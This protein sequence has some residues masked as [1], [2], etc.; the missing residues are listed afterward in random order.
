MNWSRLLDMPNGDW[1]YLLV[2]LCA[3]I[4]GFLVLWW[5]AKVVRSARSAQAGRAGHPSSASINPHGALSA[6]TLSRSSGN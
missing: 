5:V 6:N 3:A 1:P 4:L 2:G